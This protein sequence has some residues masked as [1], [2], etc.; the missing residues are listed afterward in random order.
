[1][2]EQIKSINLHGPLNTTGM[3][4]HFFNWARSLVPQLVQRGINTALVPKNG[5]IAREEFAQQEQPSGDMAILLDALEQQASMPHVP[6]IG[7]MCWHPHQLSEFAGKTRIG[8]TVFETTDLRPEEKHHLA[9]CDYVAVPSQWAKGVLEANGIEGDRIM[10][11]PEGVDHRIFCPIPL[12]ARLDVSTRGPLADVD[13]FTFLNIGKF[14]KR[15]GTPLLIEAFGQLADTYKDPERPVRLVLSCYN[16]YIDRP[17][18]QWQKII[19]TTL[20]EAGFNQGE[21]DQQRHLV[22]FPHSNG[23]FRID[24]VAGWLQSIN[25]VMM[26]YRAADA[27]VFPFFAEGWNLPLMEAMACGLPCVASYNSGA[28]EYLTGEDGPNNDIFIPLT[29][30]REA[31]ARDNI[32]FVGDRGNWFQVDQNHLVERMHETIEM[33]P[34]TFRGIGEAAASHVRS[35]YAWGVSARAALDAMIEKELLR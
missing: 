29:E 21:V 31:V 17:R 7:V 11:W 22:K 23:N 10:V 19:A 35:K 32:F 13:C 24:L 1:M 25:D 28:M 33:P 16:Q 4:T 3:G 12:E 6:D 5:V 34:G 30:G 14:E 9:E 15:K 27:G 2:T 26:L 18:G 20:A 8:Y